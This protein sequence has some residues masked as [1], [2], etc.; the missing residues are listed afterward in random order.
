MIKWIRP[1]DYFPSGESTGTFYK[2]CEPFEVSIIVNEMKQKCIDEGY[3]REI[4][5]IEIFTKD[6]Y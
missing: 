5:S 4:L 2:K 6:D 3:G 1:S